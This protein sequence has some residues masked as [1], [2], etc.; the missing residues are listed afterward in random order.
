MTIADLDPV[1]H[2]PKRLGA[3]AMLSAAK[4]VEFSF[5][6]EQLDVSDSDLSKQMT[7][8]SEAGYAAVRKQ[9]H[10]RG[11]KTWFAITPEGR[12]AL[13]QHMAALRSLVEQA[14]IAPDA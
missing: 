9:G 11:G 12:T 8:L 13:D 3:L 6:R 5:L 4:W 1:I 7:A 2:P 14:P 10:G